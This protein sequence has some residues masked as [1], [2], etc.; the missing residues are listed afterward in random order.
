MPTSLA[1]IAELTDALARART[2]QDVYDAALDALARSLG[3]P[4]ASILLFDENDVMSFVAWRN[5][6]DDYRAAVRGHTPWTPFSADPQPVAVQD[7]D[8]DASLA[9]YLPLFRSE[10]IRALGFFPLV[11]RDRVIG[12]FMLY[13]AEPHAFSDHELELARTIAM[14]IAFGIARISAEQ[15]LDRERARLAGIIASVPGVVWETTAASG[16]EQR[17][18]FVSEQITDLLGYAVDDWYADPH[19]GSRLIVGPDPVASAQPGVRQYQMRTRDG[20]TIWTEVRSAQKMQDGEVVIRGVT[21]DVTARVEAEQR[22]AFLAQASALLAASIDHEETLK[23]IANLLVPHLADWCVIDV[24]GE[25]GDVHRLALVHRDPEKAGIA[26][27]ILDEFPPN[28]H[29]IGFARRVVETRTAEIL[30]EVTPEIRAA[31]ES[32]PVG[33]FLAELGYSSWMIVPLAIG[34]RCVGAISLVSAQP[35]RRYNDDDLALAAEVAHRA[36]YAVDNARLLREAQQARADAEAAERRSAFLANASA[37]LSSSLDYQTT[38]AQVARLAVSE[39]AEWC[40][41]DLVEEDGEIHRVVTIHRDV[42][43]AWAAAVMKS[44]APKHGRTSLVRAVIESGEPRLTAHVPPE[45]W[46]IY[47]YDAE[48]RAAARTLGLESFMI[49]PLVAGGRSFGA[50]SLLSGDPS[51]RYN[52]SDLEVA[53]ELGRRA[54]YAIDNARLYKQAQDANTAKDEFLATLSHELRTPMTATL[55]WA[56]ML[57][58]PDMSQENFRLA[59]ETIERSTKAQAKLI[60]EILDVSR[61]VTG[62]LELS[63][64]PVN[65]QPVIEAAAEA[66][67]PTI[68][69]KDLR[70][71]LEFGPL[72]G[73]PLGDASRLQQVIWNL[74][75]NAVKFTPSGGSIHVA[76]DEP[77]PRLARI[78]VRDSGQGIP[79]KFLPFIFERFRQ[80]DSSSTRQ[81]GGLGL[82]L[83]IVKNIVELH[84]GTVTAASE[85]EG[86]GAAF[87]IVLPLIGAENVAAVPAA[88]A[89]SRVLTLSGVD[90]LLVEDEEDTRTMIAAALR[91]FGAHVTA[92]ESAE[93]AFLALEWTTPAVVVSDIAMPGEDGC[94]FLARLRSGKV[95]RIR[96]IPAVA[97]TAYTREEDRTRILA[98]GFGFHLSKPVDPVEMAA[99]VRQ[100]AHS[101]V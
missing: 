68:M 30:R 5:L 31:I 57:R 88:E 33:P 14:Q 16:Q 98:C 78:V 4:R 42:A 94:S 60:D 97:L 6:S 99:V 29:E 8:G 101:T 47:D 46:E 80:A 72:S 83:A 93:A 87:T 45:L 13:Y 66:I 86:R 10:G 50:L 34:D 3:V 100:A 54:A 48:L 74:L 67:R 19:F 49:V 38:L 82:G 89:A 77:A 55:G 51:R 81:H 20:R 91:G 65:L 70:L 28:P 79:K 39:I 75:S 37:V 76:V 63:L 9:S 15:E 53:A 2:L 21:V 59:V 40:I 95:E 69:A 41:V 18:T 35:E 1:A 64:A 90:V 52:E 85:G 56:T 62:K 17:L 58:M 24:L 36:A 43:R 23:N 84:N 26:Q 11:H 96:N 22:A 92:V 27:K 12:K 7:V 73:T 71:Q 44:H 32:L 25:D 61:I